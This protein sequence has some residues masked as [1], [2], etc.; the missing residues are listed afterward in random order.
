MILVKI[1]FL[2]TCFFWFLSSH[3]AKPKSLNRNGK[4]KT[5]YVRKYTCAGQELGVSIWFKE[6]RIIMERNF[7]QQFLPSRQRL[8]Q[9]RYT[10]RRLT[11]LAEFHSSQGSSN[12]F[13]STL[14]ECFCSQKFRNHSLYCM[15]GPLP[16]HTH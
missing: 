16:S 2:I 12:T 15:P 5:Y 7:S 4:N 11:H 13:R 10:I 9:R 8:V 6:Y 1:F 3:F 14:R